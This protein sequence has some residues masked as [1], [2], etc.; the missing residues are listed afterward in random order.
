MS[1]EYRLGEP[2]TEPEVETCPPADPV[3]APPPSE[4]A[5]HLLPPLTVSLP[6]EAPDYGPRP[7]LEYVLDLVSPEPCQR[8]RLLGL[9]SERALE[10]I[11]S[12]ELYG[13]PVGEESWTFVRAL[14][15]PETFGE[16]ALGWNMAPREGEPPTVR[17]L[18]RFRDV[19][20]HRLRPLGRRPKPRELPEAACQRGADLIRLREDWDVGVAIVLRAPWL[21]RYDCREVWDAAYA[22]GMEWGHLE[23]FHW[24][25]RMRWPGD[26][27]LFSLWSLEAPGTFTP[28]L[29]AAGMTVPELALGFSIPRSPDPLGVFDRMIAAGQYLRSRLGGKLLIGPASIASETTIQMWRCRVQ[30]A[31]TELT[32]MGFPPGSART[33]QLF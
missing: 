11:G 7:W 31:A 5:S 24:H 22:L 8:E 23:I 19:L 9:L 21:R 1:Q 10:E 14:G 27:H 30:I 26:E 15:V 6:A 20:A 32:S 25:N 16:L 13:R 3:I 29:V 18:R 2:Q 17:E 33:M 12:P 4:D 28:E